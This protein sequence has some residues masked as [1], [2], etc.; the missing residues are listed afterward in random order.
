MNMR[1]FTLSA[2][3]AGLVMGVLSNFPLVNVFNC[4][5]C[6]WVWLSAIFAVFLYRRFAPEA[7]FLSVGEG[8][9]LGAAAGVVGA[10][11]G[12][13]VSLI[14]NALFASA[15][16]DPNAMLQQLQAQ[17]MQVPPEAM[18]VVQALAGTGSVIFSLFSNGLVSAIF[19]AI[20]G[21][22][23]AALIWKRPQEVV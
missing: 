11:V 10:V 16:F 12:A 2:L 15:G 23:A 1:A 5:L 19:G 20:G 21:M 14:F 8:A 18:L 6:M 9:G 3:I 4:I 13:F 22:I 17:G 7:P